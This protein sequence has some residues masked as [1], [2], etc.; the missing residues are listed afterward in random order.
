MRG[1]WHF[2]IGLVIGV[3]ANQFSTKFYF[4]DGGV[5]MIE[6]AIDTLL[7]RIESTGKELETKVR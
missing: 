2:V 3:I 5:H 1:N 6:S 7:K 4:Q